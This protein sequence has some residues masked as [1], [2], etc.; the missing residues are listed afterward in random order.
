MRH[1]CDVLLV[2]QDVAAIRIIEPLD[3]GDRRRL[4]GARPADQT[5]PFPGPNMERE[6]LQHA[7]AVGIAESDIDEADGAAEPDERPGIGRIGHLMGQAEYANRLAQLGEMLHQLHQRHGEVAGGVQDGE[8]E[9]GGENDVAGRDP[10]GAPQCDRPDQ[11]A[12]GDCE[13]GERVEQT[14]ALQ[15]LQA[16][17]MGRH[18]MANL[19]GQA[20]ALAS[21]CSKGPDEPDVADHIG[22]IAA[23]RDRPPGEPFVQRT[24]PDGEPDDHC[25]QQRHEEGENQCHAPVDRDENDD[26]AQNCGPRRNRR[27]SQCVLDRPNRVGGRGDAAGQGTGEAV[28]EVPGPVAGEVIKKLDAKISTHRDEHIARHPPGKAPHQVV[29]GNKAEQKRDRPPERELARNS[30]SQ[31]VHE[32]LDR[33]LG[34]DGTADRSKD[35]AK[36]GQ[37]PAQPTPGIVDEKADRPPDCMM[38]QGHWPAPP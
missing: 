16:R 1:L 32:V 26:A 23:D 11:Y 2:N 25:A 19:P 10:A 9:R 15:R 34:A 6:I 14:H 31:H 7:L 27:P 13:N 12:A 4:A 38:W 18:L 33:V 35:R 21:S 24:T 30:G 28:G 22:K 5:H 20:L 29:A 8:T 3:E 36:H 17:P 37:M